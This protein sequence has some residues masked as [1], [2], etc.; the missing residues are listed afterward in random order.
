MKIR[1]GMGSCGIA[2]GAL[3]VMDAAR[4]AAE[5]LGLDIEI[6]STGCIGMCHNE[7]LLEVVA[8][9]GR[10]FIYG[11]VAPDLVGAILGF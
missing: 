9:D 11:K 2:A 10:V 5:R 8:D 1:I 7:P 4:E 6:Q 3:P